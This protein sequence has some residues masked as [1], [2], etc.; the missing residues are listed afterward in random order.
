MSPRVRVVV[1]YSRPGCHLCDE[2]REAIEAMRR[3]LPRFELRE[4]DIDADEALLAAMLE[5][6]PVVEL[7]GE[8][9]CELI[10]EPDRLRSM[11]GTL[12]A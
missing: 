4:I 11:M 1:L 12:R 9:V 5:R 8:L 3:E 10:F 7:D 6:I 2:A